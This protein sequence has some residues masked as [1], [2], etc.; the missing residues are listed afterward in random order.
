MC[1]SK[2]NKAP[3]KACRKNISFCVGAELIKVLQSFSV[4]LG[5]DFICFPVCTG[6]H[7]LIKSPIHPAKQSRHFSFFLSL[8]PF[9]QLIRKFIMLIFTLKKPLIFGVNYNMLILGENTDRSAHTHTINK[10]TPISLQH[11]HK[12]TF[13]YLSGTDFPLPYYF[14][15]CSVDYVFTLYFMKALLCKWHNFSPNSK[16]AGQTAKP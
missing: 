13:C 15:D 5:Q 4:M 10:K 12:L 14:L 9:F 11:R 7:M 2:G 16:R 1:N 8:H 6:C 3:R